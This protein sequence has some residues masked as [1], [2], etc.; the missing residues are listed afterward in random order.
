[1]KMIRKN[2]K[3]RQRIKKLTLWVHKVKPKR[4]STHTAQ[5]LHLETGTIGDS[6]H[7]THQIVINHN[8]AQEHKAQIQEYKAQI[9]E[10]SQI[11]NKQHKKPSLDAL[12]ADAQ[13]VFKLNQTAKTSRRCWRS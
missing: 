6:L 2:L 1:M 7:I 9:Q 3:Q 4:D 10:H 5:D 13:T 12:D 8:R 11:H